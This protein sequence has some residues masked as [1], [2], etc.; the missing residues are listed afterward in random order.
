MLIVS[1]GVGVVNGVTTSHSISSLYTMSSGVTISVEIPK[2]TSDV[3]FPPRP[4]PTQAGR[5]NACH[6]IQV[7]EELTSGLQCCILCVFM[8][9]TL[10]LSD[11]QSGEVREWGCETVSLPTL[12]MY[13]WCYMRTICA[14]MLP[15]YRCVGDWQWFYHISIFLTILNSSH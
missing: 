15:R 14:R 11:R 3:I 7:E 13:T 5:A 12:C 10:M 6:I 1:G 2:G 9:V 8:D 4:V